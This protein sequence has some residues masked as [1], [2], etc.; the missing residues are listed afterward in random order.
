MGFL[1]A[2]CHSTSF[3]K[4]ID[5]QVPSYIVR[6]M[7]YCYINQT[8]FVRWSRILSEGF[9]VSNDVRQGGVLSPYLLNVYIN[10]LRAALT[11]C[12]TGCCIDDKN[13]NYL[14]YADDLVISSPSSVGL[15]EL[16]SVCESYGLNHEIKLDHK[17]SA[18]L[19][20]R[21]KPMKM[22]VTLHLS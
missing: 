20:S 1:D 22:H 19:I 12:R 13:I 2:F 11:K 8:M 15:R 7:I 14:M 10:D 4:L 3:K 17:K 5:R 16:L 21:E 6:I 18:I 9:Q